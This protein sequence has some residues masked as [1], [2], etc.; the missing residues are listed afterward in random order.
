[1][2]RKVVRAGGYG[3]FAVL[4]WPLAALSGWELDGGAVQRARSRYVWITFALL[5]L[6]VVLTAGVGLAWLRVVVVIWVV[7]RLYALG[8]APIVTGWLRR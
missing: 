4:F 5:A 2:L 7:L 3:I 1:M 8:L 6:G